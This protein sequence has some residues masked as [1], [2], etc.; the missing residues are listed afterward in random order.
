MNYENSWIMHAF[1]HNEFALRNG[2]CSTSNFIFI[3]EL[4]KTY[5]FT[6]KN[7]DEEIGIDY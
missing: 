3:Q 2:K 4:E 7:E 6:E 1:M 5:S